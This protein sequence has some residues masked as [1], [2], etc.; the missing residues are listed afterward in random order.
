VCDG[1]RFETKRIAGVTIHRC[2]DC[3][4]RTSP[5]REVRETSYATVDAGA[6]RDSIARVRRTQAEE[7]VAFAM[8]HGAI[9]EWLDVG[10]GPGFVLDAARA[11]G[12][13]VRGIEPNAVAAAAAE[14]RGI[15]V[16]RNSLDDATPPSAVV[17]T[18]DVLEHLSDINGFAQ[19]VRKKAEKLWLIKVPSSDGMFYRVAHA[20]RLRSAVERIWQ[21]LY[22]HPHVVYFDESALARFVRKHD[23]EIVASRY[24]QEVPARTIV[25][26]LALEG[27]V[28]LWKRWLAVPLAMSINAIERVRGKSDALVM[29]VRVPGERAKI[30]AVDRETPAA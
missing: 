15:D 28:S 18:L 7:I 23:F 2:L 16:S 17:S 13:R 6:Y 8:E 29:L 25:A 3:G 12:F 26:R 10:C 30:K 27:D 19:L 4:V 11:A 22:E 20:L 9:G 1:E 21:T 24:L 5:V 14:A